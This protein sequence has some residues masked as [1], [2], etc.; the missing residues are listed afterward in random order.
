MSVKIVKILAISSEFEIGIKKAIAKIKKR[1]ENGELS[2]ESVENSPEKNSPEK[3]SPKENNSDEE[4]IAGS[5]KPIGEIYIEGNIEIIT[6]YV[7]KY[8]IYRVTR[9]GKEF[10]I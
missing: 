4:A 5:S 1:K 10:K 8:G 3:G 7:N 6:I 9:K 2:G